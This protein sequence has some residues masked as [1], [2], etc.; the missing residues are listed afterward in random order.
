MQS[1]AEI[2]RL[3][4][5]RHGGAD[6]LEAG[7]SKPKTADE[8]K[9]IPDHRWLAM[10]SRVVFQAGMSWKV[11]DAKWP[12]F[13]EAFHGFD[14]AYCA[15]LTPDDLDTLAQDTRIV[16]SPPKIASV[17]FNAALLRDVAVEHGSAAALFAD[18]P[19]DDFVGL[20]DLLRTRGNR[21][22]G[23]SAAYALRFLGC[24]G[25]VFGRDGVAALIRAGVVDK[26]P[27]TKRDFA[28]VQAALNQW[29]AE[30]GRTLTEISQI[31]A[32]SIDAAG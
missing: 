5:D 29:R 23:N 16:R 13:E 22:G 8:L 9:A 7:L 15:G 14:I 10:F 30:S 11:I 26:P 18:W 1:F 28:K 21:L 25:M 24:D 19:A 12:G 32:K 20:L 27:K 4:A 2:H 3:A 17:A 31:L 6:A